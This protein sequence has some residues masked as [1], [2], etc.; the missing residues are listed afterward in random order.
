MAVT[1]VSEPNIHEP[2]YNYLNFKVS[3]TNSGELGF[4]FIYDV[5]V[6]GVLIFTSYNS[7]SPDSFGYV[8]IGRV[9]ESYLSYDAPSLTS[10]NGRELLPNSYVDGVQLKVGEQYL[11]AGVITNYPTL[12]TSTTIYP[13]N[14]ALNYLQRVAYSSTNYLMN[15]TIGSLGFLTNMPSGVNIYRDQFQWLTLLRAT[16]NVN[17]M[18]VAYY[19]ASGN[20]LGTC[21]ILLNSDA[22]LDSGRLIRVPV[23]IE[24]L[25]N[26]SNT[27][28]VTPFDTT[29]IQPLVAYY[30]IYIYNTA[31]NNKLSETFRFNV[32]DRN[33]KYEG[34][35]IYFQNRFGAFESF[36]F[37][38][39][40][41][42]GADVEKSYY[43]KNNSYSTLNYASTDRLTTSIGNITKERFTATSDWINEDMS[44]WLLE[45][46]E[47][48]V[49]FLNY[50]D[51]LLPIKIVTNAYEVFTRENKKL[52]NIKIDYE[53]THNNDT[54]R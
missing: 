28:F 37:N 14:G 23:G 48:P 4:K 21:N 8:N 33:C 16:Q 50:N 49:V 24:N 13:F 54:Q 17:G 3:S 42:S 22:N 25:A 46:I 51:T 18:N 20:S 11:V 7:A 5:Y 53:Y 2:V 44:S 43:K 15:N 45:L 35:E 30:D 12:A 39:V 36:T 27:Y 32:I 29:A 40:S 41:T 10:A 26:V 6:D 34:K 1:I 47:S 9:V 38:L 52:F 31:S 19:D